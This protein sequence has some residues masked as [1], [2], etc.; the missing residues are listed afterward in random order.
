M[1]ISRKCLKINRHIQQMSRGPN[2]KAQSVT[3]WLWIRFPPAQQMCG[4]CAV[5]MH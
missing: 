2:D 1:L 5:V 3:D 4:E